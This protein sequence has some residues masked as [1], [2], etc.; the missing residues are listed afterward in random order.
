MKPVCFRLVIVMISLFALPEYILGAVLIDRIVAVVDQEVI[1]QSE[2]DH[3]LLNKNNRLQEAGKGVDP[4]NL[5]ADSDLLKQII[6][7]KLIAQ[8]AR[9]AG[10][11]ITPQQMEQALQEIERRNKFPN[12][13]AFRQAIMAQSPSWEGYLAD[14][15]MEMTSVALLRHEIDPEMFVTEDA[16]R[17][18]YQQHLDAFYQGEQVELKQM[19]FPLPQGAD[20]KQIEQARIIAEAARIEIQNG[21]SFDQI[22]ERHRLTPKGENQALRLKKGDIVPGL[23]QIIFSM[24]TDEISR[25]VQTPIGFHLFQVTKKIAGAPQSYEEAQPTI[26]S[27]LLQEKQNRL[28]QEWMIKLLKRTFIEIK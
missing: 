8:T 15:K 19:V 24:E 4:S 20:A 22:A 10:I 18:Y 23:E 27:L 13:A 6:E 7:S 25:V 21:V 28:A 12:R 1:T 2:L 9:N 17:D 11:E 26:S 14:L 16:A 5:R 3:Y